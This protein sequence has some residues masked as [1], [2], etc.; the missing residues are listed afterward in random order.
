MSSSINGA[1]TFMSSEELQ[2]MGDEPVA[3][4]RFPVIMPPSMHVG[5]YARLQFV[6]VLFVNSG[7]V[8][9]S[10]ECRDNFGKLT[11]KKTLEEKA[12]AHIDVE[13]HTLFNYV[14]RTAKKKK[15][16]KLVIHPIL[17]LRELTT[18]QG[19]YLGGTKD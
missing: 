8:P 1:L 3:E 12:S 13:P 18:S 7:R 4:M 10:V 14:L 9:V 15:E 16:I 2:N 17:L 19:P 5:L 11:L 6:K